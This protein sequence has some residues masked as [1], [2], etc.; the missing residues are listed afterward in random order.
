MNKKILLAGAAAA[1]IL[2]GCQNLEDQIGNKLAEGIINSASNGEV[3]V[4]FDDLENGKFTVQTKDGNMAIDGSSKDANFKVTDNTGK[5]L[6]EGSGG[7]D[8]V[9]IKDE[10][11]KEV[12]KTDGNIMTVTDTQ[13]KVSTFQGGEGAARPSD[14]PADLPSPSGAT[15]FSYFSADTMASLSYKVENVDLKQVCD[16]IQASLVSAGWAASATGMH[17]EDADNIIRPFEKEGYSLMESCSLTDN[18]P[19]ISL[20]KTK[21]SS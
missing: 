12:L 17:S 10:S 3:K 2:A 8:N 1:L 6:V 15:D 5:T 11:G 9:V 13:G 19:D 14:A 4:K 7:G 18:V 20:I 21:K 16:D